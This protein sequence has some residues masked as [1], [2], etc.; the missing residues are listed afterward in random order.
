MNRRSFIRNIVFGALTFALIFNCAYA[1]K[2]S[3]TEKI[4]KEQ[5]QNHSLVVIKD[6]KMIC[7]DGKGISPIL[8][9]LEN[10]N[11][12]NAAVGDK[13]IGRAS[14][15]LLVHGKVKQVYTP[16]ISKPAIEVLK[17]FHVDYTAE[18][19]VDNILNQTQTDLCPMEKK[20]KDVN[21]P[22]EAYEL[23]K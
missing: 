23:L 20:V 1:K 16:V 15:L 3:S 13:K 10:D 14:A 18:K 7:L 6:N 2:L 5:L 11:F 22:D 4:L 17:A 9:Y 19:V 8:R 21:S 12:E